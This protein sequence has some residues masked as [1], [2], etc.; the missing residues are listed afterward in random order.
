[1]YLGANLLLIATLFSESGFGAHSGTCPPLCLAS[2]EET[3]VEINPGRSNEVSRREHLY[4]WQSHGLTCRSHHLPRV[5]SL[6]RHNF[7]PSPTAIP[8][9]RRRARAARFRCSAQA[10]QRAACRRARARDPAATARREAASAS[11]EIQRGAGRAP[12]QA[13]QSGSSRACAA[14]R[15]AGGL[16]ARESSGGSS[17][18]HGEHTGQGDRM[19]RMQRAR[20]REAM[21]S[22]PQASSVSMARMRSLWFD[23]IVQVFKSLCVVSSSSNLKSCQIDYLFSFLLVRLILLRL[24]T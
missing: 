4:L 6:H 11:R 7:C 22:S 3:T 23:L 15:R 8:C 10:V 2:D 18:A 13:V 17:S 21:R 5:P 16:G 24:K 12:A 1:M 9:A 19:T 20:R 14:R